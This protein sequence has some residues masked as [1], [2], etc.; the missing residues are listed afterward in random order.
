MKRYLSILVAV[1]MVLSLAACGSKTTT[2]TQDGTTKES[3]TNETGSKVLTVVNDADAI[4][5]DPQGSNDNSS[6]KVLLQIYE[7]LI[8]INAEGKVVP[9]LAESIEAKSDLDYEI[10]LKKG[11]KFHNGE[12]MKA[13][14]VVFT[15]KR[16]LESPNV[17]YLYEAIDGETVKAV[18]DYTVTFTLKTP[19]AGIVMAFMHPGAS[20]LSEKAV[21]AAGDNYGQSPE[22]VCGT[23]AFKLAEW[24]KANKIV[25]DT[26]AD[27]HGEKPAFDKI[28][29]KIIPEASNRVIELESGSADIAYEIAPIDRS[30]VEDNE[31]LTLLKSLDYGTTYLG[32]NTQKAPFDNPKVR[33]AISYAIDLEPIIKTVW[34][35]VG[36]V[37][38][39]SLPPTLNYSIADQYQ[40]KK[41]DVEKAKKLLE[42]AG[43]P[44]GFACELATNERQQRIDM[45]TMIKEQLSEVGIDV[46][47]SVMEWS[48]YNDH[49][50]NGRQDMFEIAWIAD[51][52]DPDSFMFPCFHSSAAGEGGNYVFLNDPEMDK[53]LE[54]ARASLDD[55]KRAELYKK[56]Q[57]RVQE[58]T[59]W[60]PQ[61]WNENA[62]GTK[63]SISGLELNPFNFYK[64]QNVKFN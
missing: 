58:I 51:T 54:D 43:F 15:I 40:V 23:G 42:E 46:T 29:Y 32:F 19:Y 30:K 47:V 49:L 5:L 55:A 35:G 25:L 1:F 18:D 16:A 13:S 52:P 14:D 33:E 48:A 39:N 26:F 37:A 38:T 20:I 50:K 62:V 57:E 8:D 9:L 22:T 45:A 31:N 3:T 64:L 28:D 21:T 17:A 61:Y 10:K 41:R 53:L 36:E 34:M 2:T 59:A 27:Y 60:I 24:S 12:E 6:S 56:A 11:V 4:T 7:G 63:K 44:D